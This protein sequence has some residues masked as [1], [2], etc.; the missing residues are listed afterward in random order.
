MIESQ[1]IWMKHRQSI[2]ET[3]EE[4]P[5]I[6]RSGEVDLRIVGRR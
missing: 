3:H 4:T 5:A 1:P 6:I 2:A